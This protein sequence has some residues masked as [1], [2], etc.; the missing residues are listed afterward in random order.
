MGL[1]LLVGS[2][3]HASLTIVADGSSSYNDSNFFSVT[4]GSS[5]GGGVSLT[6]LT[7]DLQAGSDSNAEWDAGDTFVI[8]TGE[9]TLNSSNI[10]MD[11]I[12]RYWNDPTMTVDFTS[13][14]FNPGDVFTFG[15]DTDNLSGN[16][17]NISSNSGGA[18]GYRDVEVTA[19]WSDGTITSGTFNTDSNTRSTAVLNVPEGT[20]NTDFTASDIVA[21]RGDE[22]PLN[23]DLSSNENTSDFYISGVP[24]GAYLTEGEEVGDGNWIVPSSDIANVAVVPSLTYTGQFILDITQD[25]FNVLTAGSSGTFGSGSSNRESLS[26]AFTDFTY[27]SSGTVSEGRFIVTDD[28]DEGSSSWDPVQDRN[29]PGTGYF[30]VGNADGGNRTLFKQNIDGLSINT[31]YHISAFVANLSST[32]M[33]ELSFR[34]NGTEIF[35]TGLIDSGAGGWQEFGGSYMTATNTAVTFEVMS[36]GDGVVALD[37]VLFAESFSDDMLVTV[38]DVGRSDSPLYYTFTF[39]N[40]NSV[41]M[42]VNF[43]DDL[44]NGL[45]WDTAYEPLVVGDL[46]GSAPVYSNNNTSISINGMELPPGTSQLSMRVE[47]SNV[48]GD[49]TNIAT[50]VVVDEDFLTETYTTQASFTVLSAN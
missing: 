48:A 42:T 21:N 34:V 33:A 40:S 13:G 22:I 10:D 50:V 47:P 15:Y 29:E 36:V 41:S 30:L 6:S 12:S 8:N 16:Y 19:T 3:L 26:S 31:E 5:S 25:I 46:S 18:F 20:F 7:I 2:H 1:T 37:D 49:F 45:V 27:D 4:Y 39:T 43:Q 17:N 23:L 14:Y 44:P 38:H 35:S 9:T 11:W 32:E 24:D 28:G